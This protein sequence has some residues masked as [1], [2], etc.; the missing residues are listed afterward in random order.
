MINSI[1]QEIY[2]RKSTTPEEIKI[3]DSRGHVYW[4]CDNLCVC[5]C[6]LRWKCYRPICLEFFFSKPLVNVELGEGCADWEEVPF[7]ALVFHL[8]W[9]AQLTF[10]LL[11]RYISEPVKVALY[12]LSTCLSHKSLLKEWLEDGLGCSFPSQI[13]NY[14]CFIYSNSENLIFGDLMSAL[15]LYK[16]QMTTSSAALWSYGFCESEVQAQVVLMVFCLEP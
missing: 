11:W 6:C 16:W 14:S 7:G 2:E 1:S 10:A 13:Y 9:P 3:K 15:W 12:K 5:L 8:T 4:D